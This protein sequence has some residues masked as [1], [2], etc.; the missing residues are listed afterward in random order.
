MIGWHLARIHAERRTA[1]G[2][3]GLLIYFDNASSRR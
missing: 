1:L 3:G 2:N